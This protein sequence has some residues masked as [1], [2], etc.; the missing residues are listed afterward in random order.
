M[1]L[2]WGLSSLVKR[3]LDLDKP[4]I[5]CQRRDRVALRR[6]NECELEEISLLIED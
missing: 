4:F 1:S 5:R 6:V 3:L 2:P